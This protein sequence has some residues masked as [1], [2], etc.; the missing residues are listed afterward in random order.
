MS[1][2]TITATSSR[3]GPPA[4]TGS[5]WR[6]S[7]ALENSRIDTSRIACT[8]KPENPSMAPI[9]NAE[10]DGTPWRWKKRTFNAIRAADDGIAK[11][12][13]EMA[14]CRP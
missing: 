2:R 11:F 10:P 6:S 1:T 9:A 12:T 14:S 3:P 5:S 4:V 8:T 13:Y 7:D